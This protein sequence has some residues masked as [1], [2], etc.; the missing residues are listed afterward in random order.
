MAVAILPSVI[1]V[2]QEPKPNVMP[3]PRYKTDRVVAGAA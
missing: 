2:N 3:P 1:K